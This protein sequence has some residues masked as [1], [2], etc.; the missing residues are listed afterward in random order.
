MAE[1]CFHWHIHSSNLGCI[2]G[3]SLFRLD[4]WS[5]ATYFR[6]IA[7]SSTGDR[8][9]RYSDYLG[10][11]S[12]W[13]GYGILLGAVCLVSSDGLLSEYHLQSTTEDTY[14]IQARREPYPACECDWGLFTSP[15]KAVLDRRTSNAPGNNLCCH[16]GRGSCDHE[17]PGSIS[18]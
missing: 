6:Y 10:S 13:A 3:P 15:C 4:C 5:H 18:R 16:G 2:P 14:G 1:S 11:I 17:K 8:I 12:Q 7:W 9:A